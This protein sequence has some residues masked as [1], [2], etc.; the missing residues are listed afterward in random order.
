MLY[1]GQQ[2]SAGVPI[3]HPLPVSWLGLADAP[4]QPPIWAKVGKF[5]AVQIQN[6]FAQIAYD[7]SGWDYTKIGASNQLGRYQFTTQQLENYGLLA[8]GSN[9]A[10]GT[11]CINYRQCWQPTVVDTGINNYENYFYN[12]SS[13]NQFIITTVAQEHLAYQYFVDLYSTCIDAS[14]ILADDPVDVTAGMIY[15]AWTLGVGDGPMANTPN[16]TGAWAWRYNNIGLGTNSYNSGRY[17]I[18]VLSQ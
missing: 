5:T 9:Q 3:P 14:V 4:P 11:A 7:I 18:K 17:A 15:V 10:Y 12:I 16:G 8:V 13:L 6:L 2:A 1:P